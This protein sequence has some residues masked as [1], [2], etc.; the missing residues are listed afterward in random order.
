MKY[1]L[2]AVVALAAV[3][4]GVCGAQAP[5][6]G[7]P[8]VQTI[9]AKGRKSMKFILMMHMKTDPESAAQGIMTWPHEDIE[10][11]IRFMM[12]FNQ[13]LKDSGELVSADGLSWPNEAKIV[14]AGKNGEP[15]T[16]GVFPES[17]EF[18]IGL[19]YFRA[20]KG[21]LGGAV[22]RFN[23]LLEHNPDYTRRDQVYF[24]LAESMMRLSRANGPQAL[25]LY[26]KIV[27]EFPKSKF[28]RQAAARIAELKR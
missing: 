12:T 20:G 15:V 21:V 8:S 16:D 19:Y 4:G 5:Q 24:Y 1:D 28:Y 2:I 22:N 9:S 18:L 27:N 14:R 13:K 11:H 10:A 23:Y 26:S 6:P 25:P 7:Q 17:K 3:S